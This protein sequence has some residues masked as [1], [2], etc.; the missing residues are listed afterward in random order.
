M[1]YHSVIIVCFGEKNWPQHEMEEGIRNVWEFNETVSFWQISYHIILFIYIKKDE[2]EKH[3]T[4][5]QGI[6]LVIAGKYISFLQMD[7]IE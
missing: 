1:A 7:V 2:G 3:G 5:A 6:I 4:P